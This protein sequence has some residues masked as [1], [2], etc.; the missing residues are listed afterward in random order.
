[1]P[2]TSTISGLVEGARSWSILGLVGSLDL[3]GPGPGPGQSWAWLVLASPG[4]G[5]SWAWLVLV[6][7]VGAL[8]R[9]GLVGPGWSW[10]WL[11]LMVGPGEPGWSVDV[12][13]AGG[14]HQIIQKDRLWA[15]GPFPRDFLPWSRSPLNDR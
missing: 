14:R 13:L 10:S 4:P 15:P 11:V 2:Q 3:V 6:N 9:L 7:L 12:E 8:P 1:M 5:W